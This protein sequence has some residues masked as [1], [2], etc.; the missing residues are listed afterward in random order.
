MGVRKSVWIPAAIVV[1]GIGAGIY[2]KYPKHEPITLNICGGSEVEECELKGEE[3]CAMLAST[4]DN[5]CLRE[6]DKFNLDNND[7]W[8]NR[9]RHAIC[10]R[11][12]DERIPIGAQKH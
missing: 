11:T 12:G 4:C 7:R 10:R 6:S 5:F 2:S 9:F 1:I 8:A 3:S